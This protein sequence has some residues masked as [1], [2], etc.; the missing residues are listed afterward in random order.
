MIVFGRL[1]AVMLTL[2]FFRRVFFLCVFSLSELFEQND[3]PVDNK[4]QMKMQNMENIHV[5][6]LGTYV[7][8]FT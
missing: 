1:F 7:T 4:I 5:L 8:C 3:F 6:C 2:R